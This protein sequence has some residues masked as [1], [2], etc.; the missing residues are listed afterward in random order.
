MATLIKQR[1][2]AADSWQLLEPGPGGTAPAVPAA[3]EVIVPLALWRAR[4]DELLSRPPELGLRLE[5]GDAVEALVE[6]LEHFALIAIN[7]RGFGDGRGFST[8][9]LL[10]ER[11][12][13][14]GEL[15]AIGE[16]VTDQLPFLERCGF[17][18]FALPD[19]K[20]PDEALRAFNDFSET[21]QTSVTQ[22]Q[23]LFRRRPAAGMTP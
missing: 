9:R 18:T 17:D 1:Q 16:L 5:S 19:G 22:P 20:D 14:A 3:G 12:G 7:F 10:R 6:D 23:P 2:I 4:R 21:Y 15:R 13:Y 8:A 11:Y